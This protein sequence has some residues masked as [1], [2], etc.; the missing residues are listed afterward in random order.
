MSIILEIKYI[1]TLQ[2]FNGKRKIKQVAL[3]AIFRDTI[4]EIYSVRNVRAGDI[5]RDNWTKAH[6][7]P[8]KEHLFSTFLHKNAR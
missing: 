6:V 4:S 7:K 1:T 8:I 2:I 5:T 3:N